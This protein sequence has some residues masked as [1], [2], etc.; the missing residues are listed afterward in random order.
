MRYAHSKLIEV[1]RAGKKGR[2]VFA[3][4]KIGRGDVIERVPMIV[5]E[6]RE[7]ISGKLPPTTLD[8]YIFVWKRGKIAFACGYGSLYNHNF[9][10]NAEYYPA[11]PRTQVFAALRDIKPGEEITI[12]YNRWLTHT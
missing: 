2:G 4:E 12:N 7:I 5:L 9:Q 6:A 10:P 11:G 3:R 1:R 8:D